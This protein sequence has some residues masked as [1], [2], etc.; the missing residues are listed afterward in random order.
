MKKAILVLLCAITAFPLMAQEFTAG[1]Q[2]RPRGEYRNGFKTLLNEQQES[3]AFISQRSRLNLDYANDAFTLKFSAQNIRTWGDVPPITAEDRNGMAM[4]EAYAQYN[5]NPNIYVRLGRQVLSYDNQRILGGLDWAQQGQSHDALLI[6]LQPTAG[7][8]LHVAFAMNEEGE[9][10]FRTPYQVNTYKN[11]QM[12]RYGITGEN[13]LFSLLFLNNGY[14]TETNPGIWENQYLQ[15]FGSFYRFTSERWWGDLWLYGQTGDRNNRSV[16]AWNAGGNIN[17]NLT[18]AWTAGLG[19]EYLS[20]TNMTETGTNNSFTPLFGTNHGF[21]GL[22]D[23]FYVGNHLNSV[24]LQDYYGRLSYRISNAEISLMPH[25]FYSAA[26][27][28]DVNGVE[29]DSYLGTEI[30]LVGTHRI[31]RDLSASLGYSQM[32]GSSSLEILKGGDAGRTQN[33]AW[34]MISFHPELFSVSGSRSSQ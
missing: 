20:G 22:M 6:N 9:D 17:Y 10:V 25:V 19:A 32:F 34:I 18:H 27:L 11:M 3:T 4:F 24:G 15:T 14:E 5:V 7:H 1:L 8:Q 26:T 31:R 12:A 16:E 21:N 30:D 2:I 13:S 23:Y 28:T 29:A 33:W